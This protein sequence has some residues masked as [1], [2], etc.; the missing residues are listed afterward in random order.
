MSAGW[1]EI[2]R[3][4]GFA[5]VRQR[6]AGE[7]SRI[8]SGVTPGGTDPKK[9]LKDLSGFMAVPF[10][11]FGLT[12]F[13]LEILLP[14]T[15]GFEFLLVLLFPVLFLAY[16]AA[17]LYVLRHRLAR[18]FTE[19]QARLKL[20]AEAMRV[21]TTPLG[22]NYVPAPGGAPKG[23]EWLAEQSWAPLVLRE[24]AETL[25][26]AGG[27]DEAVAIVRESGLLIESNV[28]VIGTAE[29]KARY[30]EQSAAMRR[31]EDGFQGTR[32]GIRFEMFEWVEPV[33]EAPDIHHLVIVLKAP[34]ALH[35]VT[36][37][38]SRKTGWPGDPGGP[39]M[40]EVDLGP[41][42]FE[43]LYRLRSSDQ[44]EARAIFNPA[45]IERV[46][47][48]AHGGRF[49]AVA[50]AGHLVFDF[51]SEAN[52]FQIVDLLTG[53][54]SEDTIRSTCADL[55]EA[56]ALVDALA[57]AFMLAGKSDTGGA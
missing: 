23:L 50:R 39:A 25:N 57:H 18:L 49:R 28:Q 10:V 13:A 20:K 38:R 27:M 22:L 3:Q 52:R 7:V 35:G 56:L 12:F 2:E 37:L 42:A 26:Q 8:L 14:D 55:A 9:K 48:L 15:G 21:L 19:A 32:R 36:Q 41:K 4:E 29:Q 40:Q 53:A 45:V 16:L 30:A 51:E 47:G 34:F 17:G 31:I 43:A 1:D 6:A 54:W 24:A 33:S 46:I 5:G 11:L 44:V